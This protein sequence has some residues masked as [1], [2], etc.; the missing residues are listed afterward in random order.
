[1]N[2]VILGPVGVTATVIG[3]VCL[4]RLLFM[5]MNEKT[6]AKFGMTQECK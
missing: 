3:A 2:D 6:R 5:Q 4:G 1:M